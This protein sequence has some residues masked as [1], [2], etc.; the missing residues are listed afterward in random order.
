MIMTALAVIVR[1]YPA[2]GTRETPN[3]IERLTKRGGKVIGAFQKS[4]CSQI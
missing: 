3:L 2:A 1:K 4:K